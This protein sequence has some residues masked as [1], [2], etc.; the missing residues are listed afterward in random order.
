MIRLN[1]VV[2][3]A[4]M[5]LLAGCARPITVVGPIGKSVDISEVAIYY[6]QKPDCNFETIGLI[7]VEGGF[8]SLESL[9]RKMRKQAASVGADTVYVL[10]TQR[11]DIKEY[12]GSAKAIRCL[13]V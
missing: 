1:I 7:L 13:P 8:Y 10:H 3:L 11:L 5:T 9:F 6:P 2:L 4:L 12:I